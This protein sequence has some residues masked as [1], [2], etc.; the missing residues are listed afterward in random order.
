M[1]K[2]TLTRRD[3]IKFSGASLFLSALPIHGFTKDMPPG[4]ISIIMLEGGM[5]GLGAIPPIG[6]PDLASMR[7]SLIPSRT[8]K[9]DSFFGAHPVLRNF[10]KMYANNDAAV[11]HATSFPYIRR[12]HFEGQNLMQGGGDTPFFLRT[13]WLGRALDLALLP[14]KSLSLDMPLI[15]RGTVDIDN[16]YPHRIRGSK[17][18]DLDLI[19]SI[20]MA[21]NDIEANYFRKVIDKASRKSQNNGFF[22]NSKAKGWL[23]RDA[24]SLAHYAGKQ[25]AK[26]DGPIVSVLKINKFDT[27]ALQ[28]GNKGYL[29]D[30][31]RIYDDVIGAYKK[32]LG[33]AW[34]N[35]IILT[36]TEFGRTVM[37]NGGAGTDHGYGTAGLL[38]GGSIKKGRVFSDW[39]GLST[40]DQFEARDLMSTT[41]YRSV[42]AACIEKALGLSHD[43]IADK[44][45]YAPNLA[46]SYDKFFS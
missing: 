45:F 11:A 16:Y 42:C 37:T 38:A 8:N 41:D 3:F 29:A 44:V 23:K 20:A 39:P 13:G 28:G 10:S 27:H 19:E 33:K 2:F 34:K 6:D 30:Q 46:R 1:D 26:D 32:G 18:L 40:K 24:V 5:D 21:H 35:S 4:N 31:L 17:G 12:S 43:T 36:V 7:E 14:G 9:L 15:L 25:L 22:K